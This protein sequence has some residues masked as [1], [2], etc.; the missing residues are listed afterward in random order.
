M[1]YRYENARKFRGSRKNHQFI[2]NGGN[3][4]MSRVSDFPVSHLIE[5]SSALINTEYVIPLKFY[6]CHY[7]NDWYFGIVNYV[8]I[9]NNDAYVKFMHPKGPASKL[10]LA[11]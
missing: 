3:I 4:L 9:E 10:F 5:D 6:V 11:Q 2:P 1:T 8:S 7:E